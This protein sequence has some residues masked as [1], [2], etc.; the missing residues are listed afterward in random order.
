MLSTWTAGPGSADRLTMT[1]KPPLSNWAIFFLRYS[2]FAPPLPAGETDEIAADNAVYD[3]EAILQ[4]SDLL[5]EG[6]LGAVF[7]SPVSRCR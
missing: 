5:D 7:P 4:H 1:R 3:R 2:A 6:L